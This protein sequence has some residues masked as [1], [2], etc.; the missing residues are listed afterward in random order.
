MDTQCSYTAD[1]FEP[2]LGKYSVLEAT[3]QIFVQMNDSSIELYQ[4]V[5]IDNN[6]PRRLFWLISQIEA[7]RNM[8]GFVM[9]GHICLDYIAV[10]V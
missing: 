2:Y 5:K 3:Q 8:V 4:K 10:R 6:C 1:F 9:D 7:Q